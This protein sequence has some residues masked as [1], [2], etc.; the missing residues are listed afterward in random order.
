MKPR[1]IV[2]FFGSDFWPIKDARGNPKLHL[3][4]ILIQKIH[5]N[6]AKISKIKIPKNKIE[7]ER[8]QKGWNLSNQNKYT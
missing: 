5:I 2:F 6:V 1:I 4:P 3:A 8:T 7:N